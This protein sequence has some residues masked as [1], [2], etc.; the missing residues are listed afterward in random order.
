MYCYN[1]GSK[2]VD[3]A[4]FC[5]KCGCKVIN[6][7]DAIY[8]DKKYEEEKKTEGQE[9]YVTAMKRREMEK[10]IKDN[11]SSSEKVAAIK[12]VIKET[13][14]GLKKGKEFVNS[15]EF[16]ERLREDGMETVRYYEYDDSYEAEQYH[17]N[18]GGFFSSLVRECA[19]NSNKRNT[20]KRE[21]PDLIGSHGCIKGKKDGKFT[22]SCNFSCPLWN[23]CS[24]GSS[25]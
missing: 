8:E 9:I 7:N 4:N 16:E 18:R 12:Y 2:L 6:P 3:G 10:Y 5:T 15:I 13:G 14:W 1:C 19:E 22:Q 23:D 25:Y 21:K 24:R 20:G 17:S 11:F